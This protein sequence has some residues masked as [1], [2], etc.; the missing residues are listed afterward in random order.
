VT[1]EVS[2]TERLR[3][4]VRTMSL[5]LLAIVLLVVALAVGVTWS[6]GLLSSASANP[7]NVVSAG[8]MSQVSSAG[9]AAIMG[10]AA[11]IPGDSV[12]GTVTIQNVGDAQGDFRLTV[13]NVVDVAG[14]ANGKLSAAL[15]LTVTDTGAGQSLYD[16][17]LAG[18]DV[19]LGT[20][21]PAEERSYRFVVRLPESPAGTDNDYQLSKVT[22]TFVWNAVQSQ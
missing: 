11:L 3:W 22:A 14:P 17:Q 20:W 1:D 19:S 13:A 10:A 2:P 16:G 4:L 5:W 6:L 15:Q 9:N 18:L 21:R 12:E 8:S 7:T